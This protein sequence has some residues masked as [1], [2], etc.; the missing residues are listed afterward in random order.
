M[1]AEPRTITV[2]T[3]DHGPLALVC[4]PWCVGGHEDGG[5]R[6]DILHRGPDITLVFRG[7]HI[8]DASLVQAPFTEGTDPELGG[9]TPGVSVSI[10][11]RTLDPCG[12]YEL[13]AAFDGHADQLRA[14]ADELAALRE[15]DR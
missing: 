5:Y 2:H 15:G 13:A 4:P 8:T 14:L 7:R 1:S 10:L 6:A 11:G 3:V 9:P 12:L